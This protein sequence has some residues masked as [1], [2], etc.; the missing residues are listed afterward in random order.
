M[1]GLPTVNHPRSI[2]TKRKQGVS[3]TENALCAQ[4]ECFNHIRSC[5]YARIEKHGESTG[6]LGFQYG[7]AL[8]DLVKSKEGSDGAVYL[9]AA[10]E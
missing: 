9:P 1:Y 10:W 4:S 6:F 5:P 8:A 7:G 3:L 2:I